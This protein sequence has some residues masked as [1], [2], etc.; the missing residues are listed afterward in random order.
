[1]PRSSGRR[2][3]A[4]ISSPGASTVPS[5]KSAGSMF[6]MTTSS[7]EL[8]V[9]A[10]GS[11]CAVTPSQGR[12]PRMNDCPDRVARYLILIEGGPPSNCSTWSPDLPGCVAT[13]ETLDEAEQEM[14][15]A[16]AFHLEGL[17]EDGAEIP[18]P[19]DPGSTSNARP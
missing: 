6:L 11:T 16:I 7:S 9:P 12:P 19:T 13:G 2:P 8:T 5:L 10:L 1:M 14:R 18:E 4:A 3:L 17:A 15:R